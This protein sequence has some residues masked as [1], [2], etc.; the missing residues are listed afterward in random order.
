MSLLEE[1]PLLEQNP[2]L[3]MKARNAAKKSPMQC[4]GTSAARNESYW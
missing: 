2:Y 1:F 3:I 4:T